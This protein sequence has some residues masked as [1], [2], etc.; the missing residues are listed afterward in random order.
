MPC[1]QDMTADVQK[2][3]RDRRRRALT[4]LHPNSVE[5]AHSRP[6]VIA[7]HRHETHPYEAIST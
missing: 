5:G 6:A 7:R 4:V 2:L 1:C 3:L